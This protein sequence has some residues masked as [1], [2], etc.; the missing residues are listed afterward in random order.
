MPTYFEGVCRLC[1]EFGKLS[2]EHIPPK[3]AFN[4]YQQLLR[5]MEDHLSNRPYSRFR[6][7]LGI[8]SLCQECNNRTG[9]WYGDAFVAWTRQGF[10][11]FDKVGGEKILNLPYYL[12]PLNV[13]KQ[14][15]VMAVAMSNEATVEDK[16]ELRQ[17][18]LNPRAR[19]IPSDYRVFVYFSME[20]QP[21]FASG[22]AILDTEGGGSDVIEAE[23]ALVPFGY[24]VTRPVGDRKSLAETKGLYEITWFSQF[25]YN[26]WVTVHLRIP[27]R[28][29]FFP[30]PL[31]YR[32]KYGIEKV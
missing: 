2:F 26:E 11:W 10:E 14:I 23:V 12:K 16:K 18:L 28:E 21:R 24:C 8:Y 13:L 15:L 32:N 27:T 25:R 5:T 1:G 17:Y 4:E 30:S 22:M 7:G 6:K 3:K 9:A 29:T 31:D 19:Y 20:G